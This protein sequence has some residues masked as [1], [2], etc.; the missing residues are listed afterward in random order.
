MTMPRS[1][2]DLSHLPQAETTRLTWRER[3]AALP[4]ATGFGLLRLLRIERRNYL[5][6]DG[7]VAARFVAQADTLDFLRWLSQ[8]HG[9]TFD[10]GC[11][12]GKEWIVAKHLAEAAADAGQPGPS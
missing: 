7:K 11:A 1:K 5:V 10:Y 2:M 4:R 9:S 8:T 12:M 6:I 3:L